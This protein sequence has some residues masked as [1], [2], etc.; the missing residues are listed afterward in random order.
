MENF[1]NNRETQ[2]LDT[3]PKVLYTFGMGE[4]KSDGQSCANPLDVAWLAGIV[5]GEGS[6]IG[7]H[8]K[9]KEGMYTG[10]SV[11]IK[12]S[13]TCLPMLDRVQ[14]VVYKITDVKKRILKHSEVKGVRCS[15]IQVTNQRACKKLCEALIPHLTAKRKQAELMLKYCNS[16]LGNR[17]RGRGYSGFELSFVDDLKTLKSWG[18]VKVGGASTKCEAPS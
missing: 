5:D 13:N 10:I 14:H 15:T 16:R 2:A 17:H 7:Q 4:N 6:F 3:V 11:N 12:I 8:V 18:I 9:N 1:T